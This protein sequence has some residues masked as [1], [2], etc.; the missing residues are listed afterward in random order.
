[1]ATEKTKATNHVS[2]TGLHLNPEFEQQ[3]QCRNVKVLKA[4]QDRFLLVGFSANR[5][6]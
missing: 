3:L 4:Q 1:M 6:W 2:G 5:E